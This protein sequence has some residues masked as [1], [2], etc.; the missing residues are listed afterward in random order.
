MGQH[1]SDHVRLLGIERQPL[2]GGLE[3]NLTQQVERKA[4]FPGESVSL[5]KQVFCTD[6]AKAKQISS[7]TSN[8]INM[9][10]DQK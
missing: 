4:K 1:S 6:N 3:S 10:H 7:F 8:L 5:S 2:E 9:T